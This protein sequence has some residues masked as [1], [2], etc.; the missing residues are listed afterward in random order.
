[1]RRILVQ[2]SM[3]FTAL[4]MPQDRAL[5]EQISAAAR[6]RSMVLLP[7]GD[8]IVPIAGS[9]DL[10]ALDAAQMAAARWAWEKGEA[11]GAGTGTLPQARWTFWPLDGVRARTGVAG[12]EAGAAPPGSDVERLVLALLEQ[13]IAG[14]LLHLARSAGEAVAPPPAA[15]QTLFGFRQDAFES[16]LADQHPD[17]QVA[18]A[19]KRA[20]RLVKYSMLL[21][22][23]LPRAPISRCSLDDASGQLLMLSDYLVARAI[24]VV[25]AIGLPVLGL[26]SRTCATLAEDEPHGI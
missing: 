11:A 9:P 15:D 17:P 13:T 22:M 18:V 24:T 20:C 19:L 26:F 2:T 1:M 3:A 6:G 14:L 12:V 7:Q 25:Q 5:A 10:E 23:D 16:A 8:E 21:T 4:A